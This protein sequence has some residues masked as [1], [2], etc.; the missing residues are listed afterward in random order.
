M[1]KP[2]PQQKRGLSTRLLDQPYVLLVLTTFFWGGNTVAGKMAV[3]QIDPYTLT[4]LRWSGALLLVL[5]FSIRQLR[6]DWPTLL[7]KWW[8]Y[9][10]YG[11]VGYVTFNILVYIASYFTTG[12]NIALEQVTINMFVMLANF[13]LFKTRV[14][15]LQLAGALLTAIGVLL[16]A[17]H[18]DP[19]RLL[20]LEVNFG[21]ALVLLA[22][23]AYAAYSVALRWR[24]ASF[25][26][27]YLV[28]SFIGAIFAAMLYFC[29]LGG[30]P[31]A[32]V[33][34][35]PAITP[36][37]WAIVAYTMIFPSVISQMFYV[38][39]IDLIGANR[40]TLFINL[41]PIF[42]A[43]LSVIVL[44]EA[45]QSYHILAAVLA[46]AGIALAEITA[47]RP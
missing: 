11:G 18:G 25:W 5:P 6:R 20:K 44:G 30:G 37:G 14:K 17:T 28:A 46:V 16:T 23:I 27:S 32:F 34:A 39:G 22:C 40:A 38:R 15:A 35:L 43:T 29:T 4:L 19:G 21:D 9:L 3:G 42:A 10:F 31:A 24:P 13:V 2:P 33:A 7:G 45:L 12:I 36:L 1:T 47:R 8:L 41:I 26:L